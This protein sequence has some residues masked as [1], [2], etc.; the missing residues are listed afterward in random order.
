[1][2]P[3]TR[4][5]EIEA[6]RAAAR[7]LPPPPQPIANKAIPD[8]TLADDLFHIHPANYWL[9]GPGQAA[10]A[11]PLFGNFWLEGELCTLFADTNMGKSLLAVQLADSLSR[12]VP[13]GPFGLGVPPQTVLYLDFELTTAQFEQRY[14]DG[15]GRYR[16]SQRFY[17][18]EY[19]VL[20][21]LA[22]GDKNFMQYVSLAITSAVKKTGATV[23]IIDNITFL[24]R[25]I[26]SAAAALPL[27]QQ[28][29]KLKIRH[30]LSILVLAHT[31][32]RNPQLPL[33]RN[34]LHGS[35]M[36]L[37][38]CDAAIAMGESHTQPGLRYLKQIKQRS[39][40]ETYG[41]N[42]VCLGHFQRSK[43]FLKFVFTG[44]GRE[45][46]HLLRRRT[47]PPEKLHTEARQLSTEGLSQRQIARQLNVA[48]GTVNKALKRPAPTV[49]ITTNGLSLS[50]FF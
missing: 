40:T 33:G 14:A 48:V 6:I 31:P 30:G 44:Y 32:K 21:Q 3:F 42:N 2:D 38:F 9:E 16:F 36:L 15:N 10:R 18:A 46:D 37:N 17:R 4:P 29:N 11:K 39:A 49:H 1:M 43:S 47:L 27:M 50:E 35:K 12:G 20:H 19:N 45:N 28:L 26:E 23:V 8:A 24:R 22:T 25:G 13:I 7:G 41:A 34:D 5:P